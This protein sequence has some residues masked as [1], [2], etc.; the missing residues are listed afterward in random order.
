M[1]A[2]ELVLDLD[3]ILAGP[4]RPDRFHGRLLGHSREGREVVGYRI[5]RGSRKV[6]LI[7]GCHAD[8]PVGPAMLDRLA[9][10]LLALPDA[11]PLLQSFTFSLVPHVNPDGEARNA[12]WTTTAG[13]VDAWS[14]PG[15]AFDPLAYARN[16][17][18]ELPGDDVEFGFPRDPGDMGARPENVAV[19][20]F[21][22]EEGAHALHASFHGMAFAAGPFFLIERFW[23]ER[24]AA[25]REEMLAAVEAAGY[26]AHDIDRGG[27]KGFFR[28][29]RGFN[30]R[31]D[32]RA[33]AAHFTALGDLE[34]A[35]RFRPSSMELVRGL[36]G[37][38]L[39]LV[40]EMPLF[41]VPAE[42]YRE[43]PLRP[44]A[45]HA[46]LALAG[47]TA[48][49]RQA[50]EELRLRAMPIADQMRLQLLYLD[51]ALRLV[52]GVEA[53]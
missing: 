25:L 6:A 15:P 8:E 36:G 50:A 20:D 52:R 3:A 4:V 16:V 45:V 7:A 19:S 26:A 34:M 29:G 9:V 46:L 31:P 14:K 49:F 48:A 41:L 28:V 1:S 39:T 32:S 17:V 47:D 33:M 10:W 2:I 24:S 35:A 53:P 27:E 23:A 51:A 40:S 21:L 38:P 43:E 37:D 22:R 12:V 5:G 18:R 42:L 30:T 44:P 13:P 11:A